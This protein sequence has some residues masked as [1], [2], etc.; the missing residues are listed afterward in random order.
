MV[1]KKY[2]FIVPAIIAVLIFASNFL[3]TTLFGV[4]TGDFSVWFVLA[5][6]LFA[7]GWFMN[8]TIGWIT[9]GKILFAVVV[10]ITAVSVIMVTIFRGYFGLSE[11]LVENLLIFALRNIF[12]GAM[13]FFGMA[14]S[15]NML[16]Q[17]EIGI[18]R[19]KN[20]DYEKHVEYAKKEAQL[21]INEAKIKA[22]K[23]IFEAQK[24]SRII[25]DTKNKIERN[26]KEFIQTERE[27]LRKYEERSEEHT[28]ELQSH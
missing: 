27:L 23:L 6:F 9:G 1:T 11:L 26:L 20:N 10:A 7:S 13:G 28:S 5:V 22:E 17:K 15:E 3:N 25:I 19:S 24:K 8:A 12:L 16:L 21:T 4:G 14:I 18:Y 2:Y